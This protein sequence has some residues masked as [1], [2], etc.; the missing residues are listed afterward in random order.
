MP[1]S[2]LRFGPFEL[3]LRLRKLRREGTPV[4]LQDQPF[5][6]LVMLVERAGD[7]V[8]RA[9]ICQRLWPDGTT[10]DFEHSVNA[11]IRRLRAALG[12]DAASPCFVETIPRRGYRFVA[13]VDSPSREVAVDAAPDRR[14]RIVVLP[15][16]N[17]TG[18]SSR[19][20]FSDGFTEEMIAQLGRVCAD[21]IGV[22]ARTSSMLYKNVRKGAAEIGDALRADYL[23]EGS[24]R[25]GG[26]RVRITAQLI[27]THDETHVW[28]ESYERPLADCLQVQADVA[29]E[30]AHALTLE[31]IPPSPAATTGR[32]DAYDAY[33]A[34]R[35]HWNKPGDAGLLDALALYDRAVALDPQFGRAHLGRARAYLSMA[36][37]YRMEPADA[38]R[39]ARAAAER[40]LELDA[41]EAEAWVVLAEARRVLDWDWAGARHAYH[42]ALVLNPNSEVAHRY[43]AW[44]LAMRGPEV[45][46]LEAADRAFDLDPLCLSMITTTAAIRFF[47]RDFSGALARA[48]HALALEPAYEPA[49]RVASAA[50][51]QQGRTGEALAL[52]DEVPHGSMAPVTVAWKAHALA[53]AGFSDQARELRQSLACPAAGAVVSD[54]H[55]ALLHV[56]LGEAE[57][58]CT[59]LARAVERRDPWLATMIV[60][61][62]FDRLRTDP[63]FCALRARLGVAPGSNR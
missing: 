33:L 49:I 53:V 45:A 34:G 46:A 17:L 63:R 50:L 36:D 2:A 20:V 6:I 26:D 62:R 11:A 54:H 56:G 18:E 7:V 44:F 14:P 5:E 37:F 39:A 47:A 60:D 32:R 9:D 48:R 42:E 10:V 38:L 24:V 31:L 16:V 8:S 3:D 21:R 58:A 57:E 29:Y 43:H 59:H 52:I 28:A 1:L 19:D 12:D 40:T 51:V 13:V 55:L 30:I 4:P 41:R 35:Y 25:I 23:V 22:L 15:F 27:D 61:P